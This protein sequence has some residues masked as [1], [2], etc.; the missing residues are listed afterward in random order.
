MAILSLR[1]ISLAEL[2]QMVQ[3][4]KARKLSVLNKIILWLNYFVVLAL[5][6]GLFAKYISP[7][8]FWLTAFFGL[9][10]PYSILLNVL[11]AIYWLVQFRRLAL[12]SIIAVIFSFFT[13]NKYIQFS[14]GDKGSN[15][16]IKVT[17]YNSMLFDLYNW[18]K[19]KQSR[20]NILS[21]LQETNPDILCLQEF[22]NSNRN[23]GLHN[24]DTVLNALNIKYHHVEYTTIA[25]G[26][27]HFGIATFS[28]YPIVNKGKIVFNTKS[29]NICIY[30]DL[31]INKDTVRVYNMHLQS[32]SFSKKDYKFIDDV[33][34]DDDAQDELEN[35]KSI[36][37]RLKRAFVKRASQ[38]DK[39]AMSISSCRYKIILCGDFN[40]TPA[41]YSYRVISGNLKDAFVEKGNGMGI[42]Y[43]GKFPQFR[44]DYILHS[45]EF[46]CTNFIRN[47]ETFTDHYPITAYLK[48]KK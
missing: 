27:N 13:L 4:R 46:K 6:T 32:I 48:L 7:Q 18:S 43:A 3:V 23:D 35:S 14:I 20:Q 38:A 26:H 24:V 44:I 5:F 12:I 11:F 40:D 36:L 2:R 25:Y 37:R 28:K 45:K 9:A 47:E 10:F 15:N 39:V 33:K 21:S 42:T 22:Y 29:N 34:D 16:D 19:N 41:S 30:T 17:S 31:L 1:N 8:V